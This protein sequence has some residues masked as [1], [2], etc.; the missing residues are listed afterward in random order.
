M[1]SGGDLKEQWSKIYIEAPMDEAVVI[2]YNRFGH[3]PNRVTCTCC[4][5]DYSIDEG[6][7]LHQITAYHRGCDYDKIAGC[8]VETPRNEYYITVEEF[9]KQ[10]YVLVIRENEIKPEERHGDVPIQG[11]VWI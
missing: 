9:E 10:D 3:N 1:H 2:F 6:E 5:E 4:G 8:W 7:Y 11:Y